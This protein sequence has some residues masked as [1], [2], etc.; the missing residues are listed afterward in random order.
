M[1]LVTIL[2]EEFV[3]HDYNDY[4][5]TGTVYQHKLFFIDKQCRRERK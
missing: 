4:S 5:R 1:I 2:I 3:M